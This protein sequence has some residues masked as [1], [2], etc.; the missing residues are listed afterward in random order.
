M[1]VDLG[2]RHLGRWAILRH[3]ILRDKV[4]HEQGFFF[5]SD[6]DANTEGSRTASEGRG[7]GQGETSL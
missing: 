5:V 3:D 6:Y 2:M 7:I 1:S 4:L